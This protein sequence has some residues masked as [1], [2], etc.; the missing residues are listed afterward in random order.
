LTGRAG[1]RP[2]CYPEQVTPAM[3]GITVSALSGGNIGTTRT[4]PISAKRFTLS[5][6]SPSPNEVTSKE[7]GSRPTSCAIGGRALLESTI[8]ISDRPTSALRKFYG[9][10]VTVP[11]FPTVKFIC[12][13]CT[14]A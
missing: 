6:S 14:N 8:A 2:L 3:M 9:L 4:T 5:R 13:P 11:F 12:A 10:S 1:F 7:F